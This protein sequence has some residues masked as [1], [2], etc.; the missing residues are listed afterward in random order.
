M[1]ASYSTVVSLLFLFPRPREIHSIPSCGYYITLFIIKELNHSLT[2]LALSMVIIFLFL[3]SRN[4]IL[5]LLNLLLP[6]PRG[7]HSVP[8]YGY[9]ITLFIVMGAEAFPFLLLREIKVH[10]VSLWLREIKHSFL[11][12]LWLE[13]HNPSFSIAKDTQPLLFLWWRQTFFSL[14]LSIFLW[15]LSPHFSTVKDVKPLLFYDEDTNLSS[16]SISPSFYDWV[17][18]PYFS[19]VKGAKP[20]LFLWWRH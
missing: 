2:H 3:L 19:T 4:W 18:S 11:C 15:V 14:S 6:W 5:A 13:L 1:F 17:L 10:I 9:H 12:L 7:I 16:L 8:S 20:L